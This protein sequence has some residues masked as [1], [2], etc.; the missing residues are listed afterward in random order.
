MPSLYLDTSAVLRAVMESGTSPEVERRI[1][2]ADA[3]LTSRLATV[4]ASRAIHRVRQLGG[5]AE[6]RLA[7]AEREIEHLWARCD[8]WEITPQVCEAARHI[9][10]G[11]L[12]RALDAIHL[13]TFVTA[14]KR[15][16][17]LE[18]LTVDERLRAAAALF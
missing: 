5:V 6:A 11:K 10:P 16:A 7:D 13:A 9:A 4:E 17:D 14:R 12:L 15:I 2:S 18:M 8:I 3:L 1:R